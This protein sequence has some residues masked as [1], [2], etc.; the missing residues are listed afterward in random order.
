MQLFIARHAWAG[1]FGD[2]AWPDD[3][4]RPLEPGAEERFGHVLK[5]LSERGFR[6]ARIATS[7]YVRCRQTAEL[8][9][10]HLRPRPTLENH[11]ALAPGALLGPLLEWLARAP[12]SD[13]CWVGH[14][15]DVGDLV[16]EL[17]GQ[18]ATVRFAKGSVA[19]L[20]FQGEIAPRA[21]QLVWHV[22]AKVLGA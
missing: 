8:M 15:P 1:E 16:G 11:P 4:Q 20:K 21:A 6:P 7:P 10:Q 17:I 19:C 3:S 22:T 5:M 14:N 18:S 13:A 2:P 12:S 9:V